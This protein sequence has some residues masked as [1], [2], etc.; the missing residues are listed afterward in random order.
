ME[1]WKK[2]ESKED[3]RGRSEEGRKTIKSYVPPAPFG[4]SLGVTKGTEGGSQ[5]RPWEGLRLSCDPEIWGMLTQ[6]ECK[7]GKPAVWSSSTDTPRAVFLLQAQ[8]FQSLLRWAPAVF[9]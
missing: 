2:E 9:H 4:Q 3:R 6:V 1:S 8:A 7:T 5:A